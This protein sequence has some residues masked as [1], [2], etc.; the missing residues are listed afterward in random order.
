MLDI[1]E[2][3]CPND[4]NAEIPRPK[5]FDEMVYVAR[6]LAKGWPFVRVDLYVHDGRVF[7]GEMTFHPA[8]GYAPL[9]PEKWGLQLGE[10]IKL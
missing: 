5:E 9:T 3:G 6:T 8:G 7:F 2:G 4:I 1:N 10:L